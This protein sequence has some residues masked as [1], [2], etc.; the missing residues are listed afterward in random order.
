MTKNP[1]IR[2]GDAAKRAEAVRKAALTMWERI[3]EADCS[4]DVRDILHRLAEKL[5]M[6]Q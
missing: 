2:C 4:A 1:K 6:E 5:G 3:E